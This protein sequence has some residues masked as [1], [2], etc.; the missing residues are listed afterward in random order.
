MKRNNYESNNQVW[1]KLQRKIKSVSNKLTELQPDCKDKTRLVS[2]TSET[3]R[4]QRK[5]KILI[6]RLFN[7]N[8]KWRL[9]IAT[10]AIFMWLGNS[11][12]NAQQVLD[13]TNL[14]GTN[15][16][17][18]TESIKKGYFGKC[19][20]AGD[21]NGD[22]FQDMLISSKDGNIGQQEGNGAIYVIFCTKIGFPDTLDVKNLDGSNGLSITDNVNDNGTANSFS[23]A[24][25]FNNDGFDDI[26]VGEWGEFLTE[27]ENFYILFGNDSGTANIDL[28][29][30]DGTDGT[31]FTPENNILGMALKLKGIGDINSD[32][33]DDIA[34]TYAGRFEAF[35]SVFI[36]YGTDTF[37]GASY[38]IDPL[39]SNLGSIIKDGI[40]Q[41]S[42][43]GKNR[44][45]IASGDINGDGINDIV[46]GNM[47]ANKNG[48]SLSGAVHVVFGSDQKLPETLDVDTLDGTDGFN[49]EGYEYSGYLGTTVDV[50]DINGD[51]FDDI[52]TGNYGNYYNEYNAKAAVIFGKNTGFDATI[53]ASTLN[54]TDG[55]EIFGFDTGPE[56]DILEITGI[57][58]LNGDGFN[59]ILI[60]LGNERT[61]ANIGS[62]KVY[63]LFGNNAAW[64]DDY[65][66]DG[67]SDTLGFII[68]GNN[69]NERIGNTVANIGDI[70]NDGVG[71]FAF[72]DGSGEIAYVVFGEGAPIEQIA[73]NELDLAQAF[74]IEDAKHWKFGDFN[75]DGK[76]DLLHSELAKVLFGTNAPGSSIINL[77]N[78]D[79]TNGFK[80]TSDEDIFSSALVDLNGDGFDELVIGQPNVTFTYDYEGQNVILD[81]HDGAQDAIVH[82]ESMDDNE[83]KHIYT[84]ADDSYL[85]RKLYNAGDF[86]GD[87]FEELFIVGDYGSYLIFGNNNL[88][89]SLNLNTELEPSLGFE[90][91]SKTDQFYHGNFNGDEKEDIITYNGSSYEVLFGQEKGVINEVGGGYYDGTNGFIIYPRTSNDDQPLEGFPDFNNDGYD[92]ILVRKMLGNDS[93]FVVYG[94]SYFEK[95]INLQTC[96]RTPLDGT[97]AMSIGGL[98]E[99]DKLNS[100]ATLDFNN[101]GYD[102]IFVSSKISNEIYAVLGNSTSAATMDIGNLQAHGFKITGF[103]STKGLAVHKAGDLNADGYE[104]II[105]MDSVNVDGTDKI[106]AH[107]IPGQNIGNSAYRVTDLQ[108]SEGYDIVFEESINYVNDPG[109]NETLIF[110]PDF[111]GD[112]YEDFV[113]TYGGGPALLTTKFLL[114]KERCVSDN[115]TEEVTVCSGD[116]HTYPDG[117]TVTNIMANTFH[118]NKFVSQLTGC[119]SLITTNVTVN[120]VY[121]TT[122]EV[123]VCSGEEH[124]YPDGTTETNITTDTSHES[125]L[126]SVVTAAIV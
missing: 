122:E 76:D 69:E 60:G 41:F 27:N 85:G 37:F 40:T 38:E 35:Q 106:V 18:I 81:G 3:N 49:V 5:L 45:A 34:F 53:Q 36:M 23:S 104:D 21:F 16:F 64:P 75:G 1:L 20:S 74:T 7:L 111:N 14:D 4:L 94:S 65:D 99:E 30:L 110:N 84:T 121:N 39:N 42:F 82:L 46:I 73:F 71:D 51:G 31:K 55:Y 26:L 96:C 83:L 47:L 11:N 29:N 66:V 113:L 68:V 103:K 109:T 123:N 91:N 12:I 8:R 67:L 90:I 28:N 32:G 13:Y 105:V 78:L 77:N 43:G 24:G 115:I 72:S 117:T 19:D 54:G 95:N 56:S 98:T 25:D 80:V 17:T 61:G 63:V 88:P 9:G 101:D 118:V 93:L 6:K 126:T 57:N 89:D 87:G 102:D 116:E 70:N 125:L 52:L 86:N 44:T 15:G 107:F 48:E 120:E 92:D 108:G 59:E 2:K 50:M 112:G 79:G 22:G 119:D 124:T 62:G 97:N 100:V 58:D 10:A 33:Y 114:S